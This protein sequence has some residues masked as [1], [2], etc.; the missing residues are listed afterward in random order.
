MQL[1]VT[2]ADVGHAFAVAKGEVVTL[3]PQ[4]Q[5]ACSLS[6]IYDWPKLS[7]KLAVNSVLYLQIWCHVRIVRSSLPGLLQVTSHWRSASNQQASSETAMPYG[8]MAASMPRGRRVLRDKVRVITG[9]ACEAGRSNPMMSCRSK[10]G[11]LMI[12]GDR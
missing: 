3:V 4:A 8:Y 7:P 9:G 12:D 6:G 2:W 11:W 1:V 10:C 5:P